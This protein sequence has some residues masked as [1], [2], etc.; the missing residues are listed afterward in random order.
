MGPDAVFN[1]YVYDVLV[2]GDAMGDVDG[3]VRGGDP[4]IWLWQMELNGG[5]SIWSL[6]Q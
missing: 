6:T 4:G 5:S 3:G 2:G 1:A